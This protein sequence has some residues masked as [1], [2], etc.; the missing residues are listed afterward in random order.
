MSD[1]DL[2]HA[3]PVLRQV[4]DAQGQRDVPPEPRPRRYGRFCLS[5]QFFQDVLSL[6]T[7]QR[8]LATVVVVRCEYLI[9]RDEFDY[10]A[11]C[12]HWP[13]ITPGALLP[14]YE[15]VMHTAEGR[16]EWRPL[17]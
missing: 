11:W 1:S 17:G 6:Q 3:E 7:V 8:V 15:A 4:V 9:A 16:I 14:T 2:P 10:H 13:E 5:G 12:A